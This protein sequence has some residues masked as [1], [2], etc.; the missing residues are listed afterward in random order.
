MVGP[1][2]GGGETMRP[3]GLRR[4]TSP[5]PPPL[6]HHTATSLLLRLALVLVV[7]V[8]TVTCGGSSSSSS[9]SSVLTS[10]VARG[11]ADALYLPLLKRA[12]TAYQTG[13]DGGLTTLTLSR[14]IG[15][16]AGVSA[17]ASRQ[18]DVVSSSSASAGGARV[19]PFV[20]AF[21]FLVHAVAPAYH[22]PDDAVT[23]LVLNMETACRIWRGNVTFWSDTKRGTRA[24]DH[25]TTCTPQD[26]SLAALITHS[27]LPLSLLLQERHFHRRN[28]SFAHAAWGRDCGRS[29]RIRE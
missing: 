25:C 23:T 17:A 27:M 3:P 14:T 15:W 12:H 2:R 13:A 21:P 8:S 11:S 16:S 20:R 5:P 26:L 7:L 18:F 19:S 24:S 29:S 10:V 28:E 22:L 9:S 6:T 1:E 4:P